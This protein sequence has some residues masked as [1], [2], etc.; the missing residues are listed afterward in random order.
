[1]KLNN[2]IKLLALDVDGTLFDNAGQ[3]PEKNIRAIQKAQEAGVTVVVASGR[4]YDGVPHDQ[5]KEV[6]MP[7]LITTNGAAVYRTADRICL[8]EH[9]LPAEKLLSIFE[10]ILQR[11]V[12]MTVF[13]DGHNYTPVSVYDY[14]W[15]LGLPEHIV[16]HFLEGR[17]E[18]PDL[19]SYVKSGK[20]KIQ[21]VTLNF[22]PAADGTFLHRDEIWNLLTACP[23]ICV[24]DGGFHNIEFT[25][26]NVN[27]GLGLRF[28]AKELGISIEETM[29]V[30]DSGNDAEMLMA[31][32]LGVAMGNAS[33]EIKAISDV[34]TLTNE[35]CGVA[36]AI[37][38]Y[39]RW[40]MTPTSIG[41]EKQA[42]ISGGSQS[43]I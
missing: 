9:C 7:Y 14:V 36:H 35:E 5:L 38:K 17:H 39:I 11:E 23:D 27:K 24:V 30:G 12:Y 40:E 32:G 18:L 41:G 37:E 28:I 31:A 16:N 2:K 8:D 42:S 1:M 13:I 6:A 21:K 19:L 4:D 33:K 20:A 43:P 26:A 29:A 25:A 22:I 34:I 15:R 10:F 3:I